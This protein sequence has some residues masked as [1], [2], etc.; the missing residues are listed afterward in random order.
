MGR[1]A[2]QPRSAYLEDGRGEKREEP[3]AGQTL[4][5]LHLELDVPCVY[6]ANG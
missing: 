1:Q 3:M 2:S 4:V 5:A 6:A